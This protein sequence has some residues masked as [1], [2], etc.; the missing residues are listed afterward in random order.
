MNLDS[1]EIKIATIDDLDTICSAST[2]IFDNEVI[3]EITEEFLRDPRH[4]IAL[5][6]VKDEIVGM[7]SA[8]HYIHPDKQ[9]EMFIN[10]A[11]VAPSFRNQGIGRRLVQAM[12][13]HAKT[14]G[15]KSAWLG[16]ETENLAARKAYEAAGGKLSEEPFVMYEFE[17][18]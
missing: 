13:E 17:I 12:C 1:L 18:S 3:P 16:T 9:P 10:E 15:C 5:A 11:G 2:E 4:H 6:L 7:T 8:F 14:L